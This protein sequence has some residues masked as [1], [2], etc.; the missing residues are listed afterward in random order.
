MDQSPS[1][2]NSRTVKIPPAFLFIPEVNYSMQNSLPLDPAQR[3][4][5]SVHDLTPCF[6][7]FFCICFDTILLVHLDIIS[8]FF[9][10]SF[11]LH[12]QV[13]YISV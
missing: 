5:N 6:F 9:S 1:A 13:V 10:S 8:G 2:T 4:L 3:Q 12:K 11:F 7:F